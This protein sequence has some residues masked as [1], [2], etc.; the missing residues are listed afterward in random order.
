MI[1]EDDG[2]DPKRLR[3]LVEDELRRHFKPEFL[4]RIDEVV[5]FNRLSREDL[6]LVVD[7]QA[8]RLARRLEE[9]G[10]TLEISPR[11]RAHLAEV[12]Y[13]P[14][15]GARPL[16]RTL[17]RLVLDP[18][19]RRILEGAFEAGDRIVADWRKDAVAFEKAQAREGAAP[20]GT[21]RR[22]R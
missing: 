2:K 6:L 16:K 7:I 18:L 15:Y 13:D 9:R 14:Q 20:A 17:Q 12:G 22:G 3:R 5:L 21:A 1:I 8:A 11:L 4:N 10:V 19:A